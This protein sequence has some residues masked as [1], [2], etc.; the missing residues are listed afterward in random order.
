MQVDPSPT[1]SEAAEG[2][3][4][5]TKAA[6]PSVKKYTPPVDGQTGDLIL[7]ATAYLRL[8]LA[9]INLDAGNNDQVSQISTVVLRYV[10]CAGS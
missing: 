5:T 2:A 10:R 6:A 9:I 7:E 3:A 8:L 4:K 1:T